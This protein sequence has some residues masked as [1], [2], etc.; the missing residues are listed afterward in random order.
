MELS[1]RQQK[2]QKHRERT[3]QRVKERHRINSNDPTYVKLRQAYSQIYNL[4]ETRRIYERKLFLIKKRLIHW[5][6]RKEVLRIEWR[7]NANK[8]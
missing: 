6:E 2:Y 4:T 3:L 5:K 8:K 7:K 1:I